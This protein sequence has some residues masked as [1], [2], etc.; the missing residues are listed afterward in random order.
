MQSGTKIVS[1]SIF[2]RTLLNI[3][4]YRATNQA[5]PPHH[6]PLTDNPLTTGQL[7]AV[8][9]DPGGP[10]HI[11]EVTEI[12]ETQISVHYLG[13][14][15]PGHL[16]DDWLRRITFRKAWTHDNQFVFTT[17]PPPHSTPWTGEIE[18]DDIDDVVVSRTIQLTASDKLTSR[19]ARDLAHVED[20]LFLHA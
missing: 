18:N 4:P 16:Q 14:R 13:G 11:A 2:H 6:D 7:I 19:S 9:D 20:E 5:P 12:G 8:R 3:R 1:N 17:N 10:I 15:R